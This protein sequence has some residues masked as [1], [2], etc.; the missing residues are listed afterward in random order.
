MSIKIR[1]LQEAIESLKNDLAEDEI[2][3]L[4]E[5]EIKILAT[6]KRVPFSYV[7]SVLR[8]LPLSLY[9]GKKIDVN[10]DP[11]GDVS[12]FNPL[13]ELIVI[14]YKNIIQTLMYNPCISDKDVETYVRTLLYHEVSHSLLTPAMLKSGMDNPYGDAM[15]VFCD[16]RIETILANYYYGTDFKRLVF[17]LN[18]FQGEEPKDAFDAFYQNVRFRVGEQKFQ[19]RISEMINQWWKMTA[20]NTCGTYDYRWGVTNLFDDIARDFYE[21]HHMDKLD[22][23]AQKMGYSGQQQQQGN[24]QSQ[25]QG[26][27]SPQ[28]GQQQGN[29]QGQS[30]GQGQGNN[31]SQNSNQGGGQGQGDQNNN[32]KNGQQ[33]SNGAY[34]SMPEKQ[35]EEAV[36][37]LIKQEAANRDSSSNRP[38]VSNGGLSGDLSQILQGELGEIGKQLEKALQGMTRPA[39]AEEQAQADALAEQAKGKQRSASPHLSGDGRKFNHNM[40][41]SM[42]K[43]YTDDDL[44][45]KL[46]MIVTSF[47]KKDKNTNTAQ[48]R[49]SG[50]LDPRLVGRKD[51]RIFKYKSLQ[52]SIKGYSK[53]HLSLYIDCSGSYS[54]N[55]DATNTVIKSLNELENKYKWFS[56]DLVKCQIGEE[57]CDKKHRYIRCGGCNRLDKEVW[58]IQ[59]KIDKHDSYNFTIALFDGDAF[60]GSYSESDFKNFGVFNSSR[61]AIISDYD[62]QRYIEKYAPKAYTTLV[63]NYWH[64]GGSK[65]YSE[66]LAE[67]IILAFNRALR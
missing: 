16:E 30:Q 20:E 65:S 19:D 60:S 47:L 1:D 18:N 58:E 22:Q 3:N 36:R 23:Q 50:V 55:T 43:K 25:G 67:N 9:T 33:Q 56:F 32:Q 29:G 44:T 31:N 52:G 28:G 53:L 10:L 14:S 66:M 5:D 7:D 46:D 64:G 15:N 51:Y 17:E 48:M 26:Q 61:A 59:K 27:S 2:K 6:V 12:Y 8:T 39:T 49:H 45:K 41:E 35:K 24:N 21:K 40:I 42:T 4:S 13:D 54:S 34:D 57:L 62:N 63:K 11:S 37:A 38:G